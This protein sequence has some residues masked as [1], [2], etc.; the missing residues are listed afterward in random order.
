MAEAPIPQNDA[1]SEA[2]RADR[3][4]GTA[5]PPESPP[6][7]PTEQQRGRVEIHK[8]KRQDERQSKLDAARVNGDRIIRELFHVEE[9]EIEHRVSLT[10]KKL[11]TELAISA[12]A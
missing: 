9:Q 6:A 8:R 11:M 2:E 5:A 1:Q 10:V 3:R 7:P 4:R 12:A